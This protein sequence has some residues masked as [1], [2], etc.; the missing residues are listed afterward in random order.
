MIC[1][2]QS[3]YAEKFVSSNQNSLVLF[4][5]S[6]VN[7]K[8]EPRQVVIGFGFIC[9]WL[10]RAPELKSTNQNSKPLLR[11]RTKR[12]KKEEPEQVAI[13]FGLVLIDRESGTKLFSLSQRLA[14]EFQRNH[15][16]TYPAI[17][18]K[19]AKGNSFGETKRDFSSA[20]DKLIL[21]ACGACYFRKQDQGDNVLNSYY[22]VV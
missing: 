1:K 11:D 17:F 10:T 7:R 4:E 19:I 3:Q 15:L 8:K 5:D 22:L 12:G 6:V 20:Q 16:I 21:P 18:T 14:L 13:G 9:D 2:N